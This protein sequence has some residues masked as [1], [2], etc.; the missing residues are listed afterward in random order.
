MTKTKPSASQLSSPVH[1]CPPSR[2]ATFPTTSTSFPICRCES[3]FRIRVTSPLFPHVI[4]AWS[5]RS[6]DTVP[7]RRTVCVEREPA[8][9]GW[10]AWRWAGRMRGVWRDI[11]VNFFAWVSFSG[12]GW[13]V[14]RRFVVVL[15]SGSVV[16]DV[17]GSLGSTRC[18]IRVVTWGCPNS[19]D[20]HRIVNLH[21]DS[22]RSGLR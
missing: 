8:L 6:A 16:D 1:T 10:K 5:P 11:F 4:V 13:Y 7:R 2:S 14:L 12:L 21:S 15:C 17:R 3:G 19:I 9:E 22:S 20:G 18:A